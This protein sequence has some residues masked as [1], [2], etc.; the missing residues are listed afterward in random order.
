ML[1]IKYCALS[2]LK[3][4]GILMSTNEISSKTKRSAGSEDRY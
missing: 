3:L 2:K 4:D 1:E